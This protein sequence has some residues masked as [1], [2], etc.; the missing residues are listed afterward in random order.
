MSRMSPLQPELLNL[1]SGGV[2]EAASPATA[3]SSRVVGKVAWWWRGGRVLME[4]AWQ[5]SAHPLHP[6]LGPIPFE[7]QPQGHNSKTI[8]LRAN[9][10]GLLACYPASVSG[11]V[12]QAGY[13]I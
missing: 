13:Q 10:I 9:S 2:G 12:R 1:G 6:N 8:L 5:E 3:S 4:L 11:F 7:C